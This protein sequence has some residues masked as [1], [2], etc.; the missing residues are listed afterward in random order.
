MAP[1]L[2]R[3]PP[4]S[5]EASGGARRPPDAPPRPAVGP[6]TGRA[7]TPASTRRTGQTPNGHTAASETPDR[8]DAG[9]YESPDRQTPDAA[10][11]GPA[12]SRRGRP[13][14][15]SGPARHATTRTPTE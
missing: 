13:G 2:A 9:R 5:A 1:I 6:M 10:E 12:R 11:P 4:P 15:G 8:G 3:R 7:E 14:R